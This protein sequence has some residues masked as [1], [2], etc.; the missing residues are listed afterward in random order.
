[1][2]GKTA[3]CLTQELQV[4]FHPH[5]YTRPFNVEK[6]FMSQLLEITPGEFTAAHGQHKPSAPME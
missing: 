4:D 2:M 5:E 3:T 6:T 1:M